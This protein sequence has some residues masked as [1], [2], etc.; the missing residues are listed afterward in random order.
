MATNWFNGLPFEN[1][2]GENLCYCNSVANSLLSSVRVK[3]SIWQGHCLSCDFLHGMYNAGFY[4]TIKSARPLK[5]FVAHSK[6]NFRNKDQQDCSEFAHSV[7]EK[8]ELLTELTKSIVSVTYKCTICKKITTDRENRNILYESITGTT[9]REI[10]GSSTERSLEIFQKDCTYCKTET[11]HEHYENMIMLPDL[12]LINLQR[13]KTGKSK[14]VIL[15]KN[16][17][18]VM[19]SDFLNLGGTVY[20]LNAVITHFGKEPHK[21]HYIATLHRNGN[22]IDC[23]DDVV[24]PANGTPRKGYLFFYDKLNEIPLAAPGNSLNVNESFGTTLSHLHES[25][26]DTLKEINPDSAGSHEKD[27]QEVK[28]QGLTN[29]KSKLSNKRDALEEFESQEEVKCKNCN[30]TIKTS[31]LHHFART[32]MTKKCEEAYSKEDVEDFLNFSKRRKKMKQSEYKKKYKDEIAKQQKPY[33]QNYKHANKDQIAKSNRLYNLSKRINEKDQIKKFRSECHG[34]IFTCIC[35][36][37]DL[38]QRSVVELKGELEK[39]ILTENQMHNFLTFDETLK[40]KDEYQY[41]V[42]TEDDTIKTYKRLQEGYSL[43]KTCIV[44]LKR[45]IMPP[46]CSKNS[47]EPATIPDCLKNLTNLE[48]QLIVKNL[49]FIKIRQLPKTR[50]DA[51][52]DRYFSFESDVS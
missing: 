38:F 29:G 34:P 50:M 8:C 25:D 7:I 10:I 13:F 44:Y 45:K 19:P 27:Y 26:S 9:L 37:R 40:I 11:D 17:T 46:M 6:P 12:L 24:R 48:K 52:N 30:D 31:I 4:P 41:E 5:T 16:C 28:S 22:W 32:K 42:E 2:P 39:K 21:G 14:R 15:D 3:S 43:C 36:M 49:I 35:C 1:N 47:L 51:M 18:D 20:S 33:Q 23:N